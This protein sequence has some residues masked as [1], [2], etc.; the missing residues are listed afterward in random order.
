MIRDYDQIRRNR[1]ACKR[2]VRHLTRSR[3]FKRVWVEWENLKK[4]V[5]VAGMAIRYGVIKVE[6]LSGHENGPVPKQANKST[7]PSSVV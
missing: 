5:I 2:L 4:S 7:A 3:R 6:T 1:K